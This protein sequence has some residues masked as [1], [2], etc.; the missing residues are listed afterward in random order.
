[1]YDNIMITYFNKDF[2]SIIEQFNNDYD[3]YEVPVLVIQETGR[4]V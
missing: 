1:M 3:N 2:K 4:I